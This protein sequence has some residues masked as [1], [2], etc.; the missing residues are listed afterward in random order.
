[1]INPLDNFGYYVA[2]NKKYYSKIE[3]IMSLPKGNQDLRWWFYDEVFDSFSWEEP[4]E[5]LDE[6]YT[7]RA[8]Q[9]RD[10]YDHLV[11]CYSGGAD[12]GNILEIFDRNNIKL[13]EINFHGSF[14]TDKTREFLSKDPSFFNAEVYNIAEPRIL[15]LKKRWPNLIVNHYDWTDS[16]TETYNKDVNYDW[17]YETG[18]RFTPNMVAR[19]NIHSFNREVKLLH[20]S[21]KKIAYIW[22]VDKPRVRFENGQWYIFFLDILMTLSTNSKS[23]LKNLTNE[24]DELFYWSPNSVKILAKQAHTIKNYIQADPM[25]FDFIKRMNMGDLHIEDYY[26]L[27]KPA[28][29]PTTFNPMLPQCHKAKPIYTERD[30]WFYDKN[31]RAFQIWE[32]GLKMITDSVGEQWLN[33]GNIEHG[34]VGSISKFYKFA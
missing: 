16:I 32:D 14:K 4:I 10:S 18:S 13:D 6:L 31:S 7:E 26:D 27:I 1:M 23:K 28:I 8:K 24:V 33:K 2:N 21:N 25:R 11:L 15:E 34:V 3:A 12:S 29:Y 19:S 9:L 17:I 22:G 20:D 5:T 30:W